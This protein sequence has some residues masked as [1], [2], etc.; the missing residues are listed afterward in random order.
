MVY[1]KKAQEVTQIN[2]LKSQK[3]TSFTT[4]VD[5]THTGVIKGVLPAGSIVPKFEDNF[6]KS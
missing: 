4:Q 1:V 3:F 6:K 5:D 2:F